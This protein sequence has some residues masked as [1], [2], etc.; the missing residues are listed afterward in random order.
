MDALYIHPAK[1]EVDA[2]YDEYVAS[3]TYPVIPVGAVGL[4]NLLLAEGWSVRGLNLPLELLLRPTFSLRDWLARQ[5]RP[6]LVMVDLHWYEHSFGALDVA[7]AAKSVYPDVP[8]V[9][10][11][12]TASRFAR[13]ILQGFPEVDFVIRGDAEQPLRLLARALGDGPAAPAALARIPNLSFRQDSAV[14]EA[15]RTYVATTT[16]LDGLD[17]VGLD[18][19]EHQA[20]Y[21]GIQYSGV[22]LID[23]KEVRWRGHWLSIGRGCVFN[24]CFCGGGRAAHRRLAGRETVVLRSVERTADDIARLKAR[25]VHQVSLTLDPAALGR[26]YWKPLFAALR[27]QNL[28][29]GLY[30]ECFQMPS[31]EFLRAFVEV[32]DPAHTEV[33]LSPLSGD[34]SVRKLNGKG[35]SNARLLEVLATLREHRVPVFVYF[36]LNLPGETPQTFRQTLRLAERI[37]QQ[38]PG[39]LLRMMNTCHTLDPVS[40]LS[41]SADRYGTRIEYKTFTDYYTYCRQTGWQPRNVVRGSLRGYRFRS[42]GPG[43]VEGMAR[44]WDAFAEAQSYRCF[45]VPRGW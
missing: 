30:N 31:D 28:R 35:F 29:I 38:Y 4:A 41:H 12:L 32:A 44:R 43:E 26:E 7:R 16:D 2:R 33:A 15:Q 34:E 6:R 1:Q 22:G 13:E 21:G 3:K 24:C 18:F 20:E 10:G 14:R 42:V 23:F 9:I 19:L 11:G 39:E 45:P 40:P 36:S 8:V 17:F 37:G 25:G 27:S 5:G